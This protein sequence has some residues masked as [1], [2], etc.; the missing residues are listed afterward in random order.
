MDDDFVRHLREEKLNP[1]QTRSAYTQRKLAYGAVL[2]GIGACLGAHSSPM[3][4][5]WE[6]CVPSDRDP[7]ALRPRSLEVIV[8][9]LPLLRHPL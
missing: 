6:H 4:Q 8:T 2:L 9:H 7:L 3:E 1:Q 5:D